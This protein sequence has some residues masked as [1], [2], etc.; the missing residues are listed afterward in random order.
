PTPFKGLAIGA[1]QEDNGSVNQGKKMFWHGRIAEVMIRTDLPSAAKL[2]EMAR[3]PLTRQADAGLKRGTEAEAQNNL[4]QAFEQYR[5][6]VL[7]GGDKP[8]V[9]E[10]AARM[11]R[12]WPKVNEMSIS[13]LE[14][15]LTTSGSTPRKGLQNYLDE[16][17]RAYRGHAEAMKRLDADA[18]EA[19]ASIRALPDKSTR[20][21]R[22]RRFPATWAP[23]SVVGEAIAEL[24]QYAAAELARA[25]ENP[26]KSDRYKKLSAIVRNYE[27]TPTARRARVLMTAMLKGGPASAVPP[28]VATPVRPGPEPAPGG[29]PA[30][31]ISLDRNITGY[32]PLL[33]DTKDLAGS[34]HGREVAT[35]NPYFVPDS[36]FGRVCSF[37]GQDQGILIDV[38]PLFKKTGTVMGWVYCQQRK[39]GALILSNWFGETKFGQF[40]LGLS[41]RGGRLQLVCRDVRGS[42]TVVTDSRALP[43]KQWIHVGFTLGED[44]VY[45]LRGGQVVA[46]APLGG[47]LLGDP[48]FQKLAIGIPMADN[49]QPATSKKSFWAGRIAEVMVRKDRVSFQELQ[50][51]AREP[52]S[53]QADAG[54]QRGA[55]AERQ[56]SLRKA[57]DHYLVA[58]RF[59]HGK[60]YVGEAAR[61]VVELRPRVDALSLT[62]LK[63]ILKKT[64]A[65]LRTGLQK[66]LK[67][68][69]GT[70]G[71][72]EALEA[73]DAEAAKD[74]E[75]ARQTSSASSRAVR[76]RRFIATWAPSAH[77]RLAKA[78]LESD[79]SAA[80]T[81]AVAATSSASCY[82]K[83]KRLA[84][85]YHGSPSARKAQRMM[86]RLVKGYPLKLATAEPLGGRAMVLDVADRAALQDRLTGFEA[87]ILVNNA[88]LAPAARIE[89]QT[90]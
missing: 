86:E 19:L 21:V 75:E 35:A 81:E 85:T 27:P 43:M 28:A 20:L 68:W 52:L 16:W 31:T 7:Y 45:L 56:E 90:L 48:D 66:Y 22:L 29:K 54:L 1:R 3:V 25:V 69:E 24:D 73:L 8:Y 65:M 13:A 5:T 87:D 84:R 18:G 23:S 49:G 78:E 77:V 36:V 74:L 67:E 63:P 41:E 26:S 46:Q 4:R 88:G 47:G 6:A 33:V 9:A 2:R 37:N 53:R 42:K 39:G 70:A 71:H 58:A 60:P 72:A 12:L 59:G 83:L 44:K 89:E 40:K 76:L 38:Y 15:V 11:E 50:V 82:K 34:H 14:L 57:L 55:E 61:K 32:W 79:A 10:A 80:L 64:G 30:P 17:G 62:A 51:L